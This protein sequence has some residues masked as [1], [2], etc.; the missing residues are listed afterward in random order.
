MIAI[1]LRGTSGAGKSYLARRLLAHYPN[2]VPNMVAGRGTPISAVYTGAPGP[3]L[4][5]LGHY[6]AEQGGGADTVSRAD[7]FAA[8][9]EAAKTGLTN[10]LWEGVIFSDEVPQTIV[11]SR[12]IEVHVILLTTP[13]KQCL[14]DIRARREIAGRKVKPLKEANTVNRA[15]AIDRVMTRLRLA[16][17]PGLKLYKLD[18]EEAYAKCVELLGL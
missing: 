4:F 6:E 2:R 7:G 16:Q 17:A 15:T 8:M 12:S 14:A 18:R 13:V 1:N 9:E 3:I 11:L 5:A 10:I